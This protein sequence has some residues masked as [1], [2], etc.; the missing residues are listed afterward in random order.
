MS[1]QTLLP[2]PNIDPQGAFVRAFTQRW[3]LTASPVFVE[4][5]DRGYEPNNCHI[6][7]KHLVLEANGRRVHGWALW[8]YSDFLVAEFHSVWERPD[9]QLVD[10][11]P[12]KFGA[13]Q[14]LFVVDPTCEIEAEDGTYLFHTDRTTIPHIPFSLQG[15]PT[16]YSHWR[17]AD[18]HPELVRYCSKLGLPDTSPL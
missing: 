15:N 4:F 17:I 7:V 2:N 13:S 10:V 8:E 1:D 9:G 14:V 3:G 12:P 16:E 11:T 18:D 6:S 5:E